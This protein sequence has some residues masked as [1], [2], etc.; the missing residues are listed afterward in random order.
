MKN[1]RLTMILL[2]LNTCPF[3]SA[4]NRRFPTNLYSIVLEPKWENIENNEDKMKQFG[5]KWLLVGSI[6]FKKKS[7]QIVNLSKLTLHW[8]GPHLKNLVGSLYKKNPDRQFFAIEDHLL[9]DGQ[10]NT[11]KQA[12]IFNFNKV[13][14]LGPLNIYYITLTIHSSLEALIKSGSFTLEAIGLPD[15]Y[16]H[17]A[18]SPLC[19][20]AFT[21]L[22]PPIQTIHLAASTHLPI[23][24]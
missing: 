17:Q 9:C 13:Q 8:R 6:T 7:K 5:T 3:L 19:K 16:H 12:L 4:K 20:I 10:W 2:L 18:Q 14:L 21:E 24:R 1:M 11:T 22:M 23:S 15:Q